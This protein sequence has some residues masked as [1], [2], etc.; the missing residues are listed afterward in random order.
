MS[1]VPEELR[2]IV[3][4]VVK[5]HG[6]SLYHLKRSGN[7]LEVY[8]DSQGG[9]TLGDCERITR[10]L[11]LNLSTQRDEWRNMALE[12]STPGIERQ[13]YEPEHYR[14]AV[15]ERLHVKLAEEVLEGRLQKADEEGIDLEIAGVS[16]RL[17]YN[18][19]LS[20][21]VVRTTE[22]LFKRR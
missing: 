13:L 18:E 2:R 20:A 14:K 9:A 15:G 3:V 8:I 1:P 17:T 21:R 5:E 10:Q 22:E 7:K 4:E 12:V 6:C 11:R 19:I 16:R